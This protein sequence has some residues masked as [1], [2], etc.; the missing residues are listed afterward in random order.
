MLFRSVAPRHV[1][2][3]QTRARTHVPCIG[4]QIL[5]HCAT[6]EAPA[7]RFLTTVPRGKPHRFSL[8]EKMD[9]VERALGLESRALGTSPTLSPTC[10]VNLGN[11]LPL[12]MPEF[13]H[14]C[15]EG[16]GGK[17]VGAS[18]N[19]S[20]GRQ[21]CPECPLSARLRAGCWE[22]G[23]KQDQ[24]SP[25]S[26]DIKISG[27]AKARAALKCSNLSW[28]FMGCATKWA[29]QGPPG[30]AGTERDLLPG[31]TSSPLC[32]LAHPLPHLHPG[33]LLQRASH[34]LPGPLAFHFQ[35][36]VWQEISW[37]PPTLPASPQET[38]LPTPSL[39]HQLVTWLWEPSLCSQIA[40]QVIFIIIATIYSGINLYKP[41]RNPFY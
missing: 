9:V 33:S 7:G 31:L 30:A 14:L 5:N 18:S 37:S 21:G 28:K 2:S 4:R 20:F 36:K 24:P 23:G 11:T 41:H 26:Q 3:S 6:R 13:P 8:V 15:N 17:T 25:C 22:Y 40:Q 38:H 39:L 29:G 12:F 16:D 19:H 1:G 32:F 35:G 27:E 34:S 10:T